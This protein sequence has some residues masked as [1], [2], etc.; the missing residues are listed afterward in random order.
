MAPLWVHPFWSDGERSANVF[1]V[2]PRPA[3]SLSR[4]SVTNSS[5]DLTVPLQLQL[6]VF[7]IGNAFTVFF[8]V[9]LYYTFV[10]I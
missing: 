8:S 10:V 5:L 2:L 9:P 3:T 6:S 4:C 1:P 7:L